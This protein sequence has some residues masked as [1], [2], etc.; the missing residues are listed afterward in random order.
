MPRQTLSCPTLNLKKRLKLKTWQEDRR[1]MNAHIDKVENQ[2]RAELNKAVNDL[3]HC[4]EVRGCV[5]LCL[6][7]CVL[8]ET[9]LLVPHRVRLSVLFPC[10]CVCVCVCALA[11]TTSLMYRRWVLSAYRC[12]LLPALLVFSYVCDGPCCG[13]SVSEAVCDCVRVDTHACVRVSSVCFTNRE[14]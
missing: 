2:L 11:S 9:I 6:C 4:Q 14:A 13:L 8:A 3:T 1:E 7:V 12:C 10:V 5:S